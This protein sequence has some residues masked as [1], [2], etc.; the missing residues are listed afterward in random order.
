M[1][2]ENLTGTRIILRDGNLLSRGSSV[3]GRRL[4]LIG[5]AER[6]PMYVPLQ[7]QDESDL[8][9]Y[10]GNS[11]YGN[12]IVAALEALTATTE[13]FDLWCVRIGNGSTASLDLQETTGTGVL[14]DETEPAMT[15][16]ASEPGADYNN[17]SIR[18][19][20]S[21]GTPKVVLYNAIDN[22]TRYYPYDSSGTAVGYIH[23]V[24]ELVDT[25]NADANVNARIQAE[26]HAREAGEFE[27]KVSGD[28]ANLS[29]VTYS[30]N[31][32]TINFSG[33][34]L[35]NGLFTN[36]GSV[37]TTDDIHYAGTVDGDSN[38]YALKL[39][40]LNHVYNLLEAKTRISISD[41]LDLQ[42]QYKTDLSNNV[43]IKTTGYPFPI[44]GIKFKQTNQYVGTGDGATSEFTIDLRQPLATDTDVVKI[45]NLNSVTDTLVRTTDYTIAIDHDY[46]YKITLLGGALEK[47]SVL[48][49]GFES[50]DFLAS[51]TQKFSLTETTATNSI[52]NYFIAGKTIYFGAGLPFDVEIT[53]PTDS[54]I[55]P[56]Y[57]TLATDSSGEGIGIK[58]HEDYVDSDLNYF[59]LNWEYLPEWILLNQTFFLSGGSNGTVLT[60]TEKYNELDTVL[61]AIN[62]FP[63]D[64]IVPVRYFVD[65]LKTIYSPLN[66]KAGTAPADY[67][68]LLDTHLKDRLDYIG[69]TMAVLS[70]SLTDAID[71]TTVST[72][73]SDI[74][75][76]TTD[77]YNNVII[78]NYLAGLS[79]KQIVVTFGAPLISHNNIADQTP[80]VGTPEV[81]YGALMAATSEYEVLT[82]SEP[83]NV[84]KD[85]YELTLDQINNLVGYKFIPLGLWQNKTVFMAA[86]TFAGS[87][88]D[89]Q[90]ISS[91][92]IVQGLLKDIDK[93]L[94]PYYKKLEFSTN[95]QELMKADTDDVLQQWASVKKLIGPS[96][97]M[98]FYATPAEIQRGILHLKLNLIV[99]FELK[100]IVID[101]TLDFNK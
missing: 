7:I 53:Y 39:T 54:I 79:S 44:T 101:T 42:G 83:N 26:L 27:V 60:S 99:A 76:T 100:N 95:K 73:I 91:F 77:T 8:E 80:Y 64:V 84:I 56:E 70:V 43:K 2:Y 16:T 31:Y 40:A 94:T 19:D 97:S 75:E 45:T 81:I 18:S 23:N 10:F 21:T 62:T 12:L 51:M 92:L 96:Y 48:T 3:V 57:F 63:V 35:N 86:D 82:H 17:I 9:T 33:L 49:L 98:K 20:N 32:Y 13:P 87:T 65:E 55:N 47:G 36:D 61:K 89:Y 58:I 69:A 5:T 59:I 1:A 25:I 41:D 4:L 24:A 50:D 93:K 15:L 28:F 78:G 72:K 66:G 38:P 68:T 29:G 90:R 67:F 52:Y 74:T 6:G 85:M 88:S 14:A 46:V 71:S 22:I 34:L 11:A 37:F 30:D